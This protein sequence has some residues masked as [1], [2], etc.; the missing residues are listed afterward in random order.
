MLAS[1]L[2]P[3]QTGDTCSPVRPSG[4]RSA[5]LAIMRR[6]LADAVEVFE[7]ELVQPFEGHALTA[8]LVGVGGEPVLAGRHVT[9]SRQVTVSGHGSGPS[10][11]RWSLAVE[12]FY[13][14][15]GVLTSLRQRMAD[16]AG[17]SSPRRSPRQTGPAVAA[18]RVN[19]CLCWLA[20][21]L[22]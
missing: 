2:V 8:E 12:T 7:R 20:C 21:S 16:G 3:M 9:I 15:S 18:S 10:C 11:L 4:R 19:R 6:L 17:V 14:S 22:T 13:Q 5:G 1:G